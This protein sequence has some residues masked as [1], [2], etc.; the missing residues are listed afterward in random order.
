MLIRMRN[1]TFHRCTGSLPENNMTSNQS[2]FEA[3]SFALENKGL[4]SHRPASK[5]E[6]RTNKG[7]KALPTM[8]LYIPEIRQAGEKSC[9][10]CERW[11]AEFSISQCSTCAAWQR[12]HRP[13]LL[14]LCLPP[15]DKAN[16]TPPGWDSK[17]LKAR[18]H[19]ENRI[20][21]FF[22]VMCALFCNSHVPRKASNETHEKNLAWWPQVQLEI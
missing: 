17:L 6:Q 10:N 16:R 4:L 9:D 7:A 8:S 5:S 13:Q 12:S 21:R 11:L 1:S 18:L 14:Y 3:W 20:Q 19:L 2:I 22:S 15:S